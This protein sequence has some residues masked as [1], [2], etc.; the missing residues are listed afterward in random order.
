MINSKNIKTNCHPEERSELRILPVLDDNQEH[1]SDSEHTRLAN[2][3]TAG[4]LRMTNKLPRPL[5][6]GR[7][8]GWQFS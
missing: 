3:S 4:C 5:G 7:G 8:E 2:D 1:W 6:E